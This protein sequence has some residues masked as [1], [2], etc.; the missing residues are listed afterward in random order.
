MHL[1]AMGDR[2]VILSSVDAANDLLEKRS[3]IYSGRPH[4]EVAITAGWG[5]GVGVLNYSD[6]WRQNRRMYQQILRPD[7]IVKLRPAI[8]ECIGVFVQNLVESPEKFMDHIAV[9]SGGLALKIMYGVT[10]KTGD[11]P[12][13]TIAKSAAETADK[14]FTP[15]FVAI[16]R[17]CPFIMS[18][19]RW[20][21]VLGH[22][23]QYLDT[24]K[25]WMTYAS[26]R[27]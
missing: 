18:V 5:F 17:C 16:L 22:T 19:P 11:E 25:I 24:L 20:V 7:A 12:L 21:P 2:I 8:Q 1:Q 23:R 26:Y 10:V 4:E 6:T 15:S 27:F 13:I 9:L 14:I 3:R